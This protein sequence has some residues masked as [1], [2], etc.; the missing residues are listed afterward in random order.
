VLRPAARPIRRVLAARAFRRDAAAAL[1]RLPSQPVAQGQPGRGP[2]LLGYYPSFTTNPYQSLLYGATARHG[3]AAVPIRTVGLIP[4]LTRLQAADMRT[5]LHLHW[6]HRI[7]GRA[8]TRAGAERRMAAFLRLVDDHRAA[9]GQVAWTV[10]NI[11][12]HE[13]RFEDLE[14]RLSAEVAARADV[15]HVLAAGTAAYV[16]PYFELPPD[17]LLYVPHPSYL[18]AHEDHVT[19][20]AARQALGIG[21]DEFVYAVVGAIR[22]YKGLTTLLDAWQA[23]PPDRPRRLVIAGAA[24]AEPGIEALL[25]RAGR[26]PSVLVHPRKIPAQEIQRFMRAADVAVLPYLRSLNSGALALAITFGLPVI[27][28]EGG[29]LAEM[30]DPSFARAVPPGDVAALTAALRDAPSWATDAARAAA[31]ERAAALAPAV[32]AERFASGLRE[33]LDA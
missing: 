28:P 21:A 7:L 22:P 13:A 15:I 10:H 3:I 6:L 11:L 8:D 23:L 27:V 26:D 5:V 12:P 2:L 14:A 31:A 30:T 25:E 16:A 20:A 19:R 9:G 33:R 4:E 18:G 29:G 24:A 17:R 1:A 32:M